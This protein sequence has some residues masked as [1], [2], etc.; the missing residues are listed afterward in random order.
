MSTASVREEHR[1]DIDESAFT[2]VLRSLMRGVPEALLAVFVDEEGECID[3]CSSLPPFDTKIAGAQLHVMVHEIG[4]IVARLRGGNVWFVHVQ[5]S[6]RELMVRRVSD[7]YLLVLVTR[8]IRVEGPLRAALDAT[9]AALRAEGEI[10][11]PRWEPHRQPLVVETREARGWG[12]AP[13]IMYDRGVRTE[14]LAVLG[15]FGEGEGAQR[16]DVFLV[17]TEHGEELTLAHRLDDGVWDRR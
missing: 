1:R 3:Y 9:V 13:E 16:R 7:E 8:P 14:I 2:G 10:A 5:G 11:R 17:R 6:E 12:Y 15:W 4:P